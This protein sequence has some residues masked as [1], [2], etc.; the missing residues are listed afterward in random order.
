[1]SDPPGHR[2]KWRGLALVTLFSTLWTIAVAF[3]VWREPAAY[4]FGPELVGRHHDP[5]T[6]MEQYEAGTVPRPYFQPATDGPG[7]LLAKAAGGVTAYN[8]LILAS[9]VLTAV[10]AYLHAHHVIGSSAGAAVAAMLFAQA[11]FHVA[12]AAY[13]VHIAQIQ[14]IP[15]FFLLLWRALDAPGP[16][17]A[18]VTGLALLLVAAA[19]LYLGFVTAVVAPVAALAFAQAR[20]RSSRP[21]AFAWCA[22]AFAGAAA[23]AFAVTAWWSPEVLR[24]PEAFAFPA[25]AVEPHSARWWSYLLPPAAHPWLGSVSLDYWRS[26]GVGEGLLE[27]QVSLGASVIALAAIGMLSRP[28]GGVGREVPRVALCLTAAVALLCSLPPT[29]T[30]GSLQIPMPSAL[31][32]HLAPMFRAYAR[33]G[34]VVSLMVTTLAGAGVAI[35]LARRSRASTTLATVL[36]A[37]AAFEYFP[38]HAARDT[39]PTSAH[40]ALAGLTNVRMF[41]CTPPTPGT[42][43]GVGWL[44]RA[45]VMFPAGPFE[46]CSEPQF[47]AKLAL[48]GFT[49]LVADASSAGMWIRAGGVV[50]GTRVLQDHA[51]AT[52]FAVI[53]QPPSVY[54]VE[55]PGFYAREI[56]GAASWRWMPQH[57]SITLANRTATAAGGTLEMELDAFDGMRRLRIAAPGHP[58]LTIEVDARRQWHRV[59]PLRLPPGTSQLA[60]TADQ[61]AAPGG[62]LAA[63]DRRPLSVRLHQWRWLPE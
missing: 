8:T 45:E 2:F 55:L 63:G 10:L 9:F 29:A 62:V 11:P 58:D 19:S 49:V 59:G 32:F 61:A 39:L 40:R 12:Q 41:D 31:L 15:L 57:A 35:L 52:T 54:I 48:F 5:F 16:T 3:P 44:M 14:W 28:T 33:F 23:V 13:H 47:G 27:Q 7:I 43:G 46:D 25:G 24:N 30:I 18:T 6:V 4:V 21:A 42:T 34:V 53:A 17:R 38:A 56:Q 51:D 20:P 22:A 60:L 26:A 1:M 36:V 50:E 37:L